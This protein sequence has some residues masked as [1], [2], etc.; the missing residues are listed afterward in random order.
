MLQKLHRGLI[1][2]TTEVEALKA[3]IRQLYPKRQRGDLTE[4]VF[5]K[6]LTERTLD[7]YR[8]LLK[9]RFQKGESIQR[10]H[11]VVRAHTRLTKSVL[12]E[13]EQEAVSLFATDRR[14]FCVQSSLMPD[15][16]P[17]A[18]E[19]DQTVIKEI[20]FKKNLTL[21]PRLQ[22]RWGEIGV[23]AAMGVFALLFA[24]WLSFTGPFLIGLGAAGMVHGLILPNRWIEVNT[25][26]ADPKEDLV[27]ILALRKKSARALV[28]FLQ[29]RKGAG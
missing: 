23:G 29:V 4:K 14:L 7:L 13:P 11:H 15:Y 16:P 2:M 21:T 27:T 3:K 18:D 19:K 12:R 8:A 10:E 17:T 1:L 24:S 26:D 5:Q 20:P 28:Q 6:E 9:T 22:I 25:P